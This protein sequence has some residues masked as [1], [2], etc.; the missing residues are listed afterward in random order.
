TD[1][2]GYN[3]YN[4][5]LSPLQYGTLPPIRRYNFSYDYPFQCTKVQDNKAKCNNFYNY[6]YTPHGMYHPQLYHK[7]RKFG[8]YNS[9]LS[10]KYLPRYWLD[11]QVR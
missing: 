1:A 7:H 9:Y 4:P 11:N 10:D 6:L 3:R 8:P 2:Y 5:Y